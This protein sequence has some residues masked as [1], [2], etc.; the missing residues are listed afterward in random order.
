MGANSDPSNRTFRAGRLCGSCD[1]VSGRSTAP[2]RPAWKA[3]GHPLRR[4]AAEPGRVRRDLGRRFAAVPGHPAA[5][6]GRLALLAWPQPLRFHHA[7]FEASTRTKV[8]GRALSI[9]VLIGPVGDVNRHYGDKYDTVEYNRYALC[10]AQ[11]A[12]TLAFT[13]DGVNASI[14]YR[15]PGRLLASRQKLPLGT[16]PRPLRSSPR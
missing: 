5:Q 6:T 16:P 15:S 3:G 11:E 10:A 8:L 13:G 7:A 12:G 4:T 2:D 14:M 1:S 9:P